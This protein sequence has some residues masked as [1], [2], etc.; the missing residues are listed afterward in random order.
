MN[1]WT[2]AQLG[3]LIDIKHGYAF[4][5]EYFREDPP[6]QILLTPGN[7]AIGGGFQFG[8]VKYYAGPQAPD[9][10]LS[11]GDLLVTMTDLSKTGD[12]LGYPAIVPADDNVYLHNQRLGK[13][14]LRSADVERDF[15]YWLL[16]TNDYRA[17]VLASCT[18]STVKHTSPGRIQA[19]RFLL[20]P[21]EQRQ[22]ICET[23][24]SLDD[25]IEL[26]RRMN[27]TLEAMAQAIF[28]DWFVDFGPTRRKLE[29]A[30]DPHTIMGGLVQNT[31]RAQGL[32]ALFPDALGDDGLPEGWLS[33]ELSALTKMITK[34]TT[35]TATDLSRA[36][37]PA[38]VN[39][40]RVNCLSDNGEL[41]TNKF[42]TIPSSLHKGP[43]KRSILEQGDILYS[44]AGT[45]G[46]LCFVPQS[47]LPA[48]AN[49]ALAII[50]AKTDECPANFLYVALKQPEIREGLHAN[51]V[52]AVQAN[53]SL[54]VLGAARLIV[55]PSAQLFSMFTMIDPIF[56]KLRLNILESRTLAATR[57]L[58]LPK[59]MSGEI[60][61]S[62]ARDLIEAA[63]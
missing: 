37:D 34:G 13:V 27:E 48:N 11:A 57:D 63:Q 55:P 19:F 20:P 54:A 26:N 41:L 45:I 9:Y 49:Q 59:L 40:I 31:E 38:T 8:K 23:L 15:I 36:E 1:D 47:I 62:E 5:G 17:E 50:R 52:H 18:G 60:R 14:L 30:T 35:P 46:R 29:G 58:L 56:A 39:Y 33:L 25:K 44:I 3:D 2:P 28:R 4:K 51:V 42:T 61:L 43:L 22:R 24:N 6:G 7:F 16:R 32:A 21:K 53:L 12:T 10:V